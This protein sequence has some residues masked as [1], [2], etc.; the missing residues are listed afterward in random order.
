M[1]QWPRVHE[2]HPSCTTSLQIHLPTHPCVVLC[3][4]LLGSVCFL[5]KCTTLRRIPVNSM[6]STQVYFISVCFNGTLSQDIQQQ[7]DMRT[8]NAAPFPSPINQFGIIGGFPCS[9]MG[10]IS[11]V[12]VGCTSAKGFSEVSPIPSL[13][14]IISAESVVQSDRTLLAYML[15]VM[16]QPLSPL[17]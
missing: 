12:V 15:A 17:G 14:V 2:A 4:I 5:T 7:C 8:Y 13:S 10:A 3:E 16:L 9:I 1:N 11:H 6:F